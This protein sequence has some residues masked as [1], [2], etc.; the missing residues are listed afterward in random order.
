MHVYKPIT[1]VKYLPRAQ[2]GLW[3]IFRNMNLGLTI[4]QGGRQGRHSTLHFTDEEIEIEE[5]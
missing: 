2:Y 4:S 3:S 5:H 1:T